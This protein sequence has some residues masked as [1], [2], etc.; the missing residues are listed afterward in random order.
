[1]LKPIEIVVV[2][3]HELRLLSVSVQLLSTFALYPA[4]NIKDQ[5]QFL[6]MVL[7][8]CFATLKMFHRNLREI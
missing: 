5:Y 7:C 3:I 6:K 8:L 4:I 1:M 2:Q